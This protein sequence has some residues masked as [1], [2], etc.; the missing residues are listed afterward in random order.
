M[1]INFTRRLAQQAPLALLAASTLLAGCAAPG[2]APEIVKT[3]APTG[4]LRIGVCPGS[5]TSL[6]RGPGADEMRGVTVDIGRELARR[7]GVPVA[8]VVLERVPEVVEALKSGRADFTNTNASPARAMEIDFTPAVVGLESGYLVPAGS[9]L[10]SVADVDRAG[11]RVG[12]TQGSTSQGVLT[13]ELK[14]AQ[15][16]VAPSVIAVTQM[17]RDGGLESY[18]TN[19]GILF[20]MSDKLPGS[21][22][23]EG[24]FGPERSA[25]GVPRGREAA[26]VWLKAFAA[27]VV[28]QGLVQQA[29]ARAGLRGTVAP[30]KP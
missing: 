23:L 1:H 29:A 22:V 10:R 18:A 26:A 20:E 2:V 11:V 27:D 8:Y 15:V 9:S 7:P 17:L 28:E 30:A 25:I 4:T 14:Q 13:R 12:V 16:V 21:C 24:R 5:P 6:V 19:K 3:L